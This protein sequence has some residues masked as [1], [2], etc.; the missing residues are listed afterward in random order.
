MAIYSVWLAYGEPVIVADT[1]PVWEEP[2]KRA[3]L[4]VTLEAD[5]YETAFR[6]YSESIEAPNGE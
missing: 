4:V 2:G 6:L 3:S 5:D 1:E